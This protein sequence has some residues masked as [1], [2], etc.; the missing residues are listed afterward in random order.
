MPSEN[1]AAYQ[2]DLVIQSDR[3]AETGLVRE[4]LQAGRQA[5]EV[6]ETLVQADPDAYRTVLAMAWSTLSNRLAD[7]GER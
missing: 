1:P 6:S 5:V 2:P 3:L 7:N 4:G